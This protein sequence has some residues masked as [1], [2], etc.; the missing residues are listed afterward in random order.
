[1]CPQ[2]GSNN[3]RTIEVLIGVSLI[4]WIEV[5]RGT[6]PVGKPSPV[7]QRVEFTG[8]TQVDWSDSTSIGVACTHCEWEWRPDDPTREIRTQEIAERLLPR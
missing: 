2:C 8:Y 3:V 7:G 1:M 6:V 5:T 4:E